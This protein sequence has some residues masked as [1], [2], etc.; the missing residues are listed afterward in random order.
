MFDFLFFCG[1]IIITKAFN[2]KKGK[3]LWENKLIKL[4]KN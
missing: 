2:N 1:I 4:K 3:F